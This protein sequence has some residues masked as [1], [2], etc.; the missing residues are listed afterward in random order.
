MNFATPRPKKMSIE[1]GRGLVVEKVSLF[2]YLFNLLLRI[3]SF[4]LFVHRVYFLLLL[5][6]TTVIV[7]SRGRDHHQV[8]HHFM[9]MNE[10]EIE[11]LKMKK[12]KEGVV[13]KVL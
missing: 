12:Y 2:S 1:V 11:I 9:S 4:F 7:M 6:Q 10:E 3:K 13:E 5:T 8:H